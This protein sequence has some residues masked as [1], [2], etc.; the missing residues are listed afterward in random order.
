MQS[1][2]RS[3]VFLL[4]INEARYIVTYQRDST[5]RLSAPHTDTRTCLLS[6]KQLCRNEPPLPLHIVLAYKKSTESFLLLPPAHGLQAQALL[7]LKVNAHSVMAQQLLTEAAVPH[8]SHPLC[9][10]PL[11]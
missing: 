10:T 2:K 9:L 4:T 5:V 8:L 7:S 1:A 3:N 6:E 11:A